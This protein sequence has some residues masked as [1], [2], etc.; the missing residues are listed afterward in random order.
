M[1]YRDDLSNHCLKILSVTFVSISI[2]LTPETGFS[3]QGASNQSLELGN[4]DSVSSRAAVRNEAKQKDLLKKVEKIRKAINKEKYQEAAE[5]SI[6]IL[7]EEEAESD[8]NNFVPSDFYKEAYNCLCVSTTG[9]RQVQYA[10]DAC[11]TSLIMN[12]DHWETLKSR[13]TLYYLTADYPNALKDFQSALTNAPD[14][15]GI[16]NALK[17]NITVVESKIQ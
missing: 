13:A 3:Q 4:S 1:S 17:Q 6:A 11:N 8:M 9:L 16:K 2:I 12:K 10:M 15:K 7:E 14:E 5:Q